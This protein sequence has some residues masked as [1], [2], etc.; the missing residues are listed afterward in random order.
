[1]TGTMICGDALAE[2]KKM[3]SGTF[4][5]IVTSPPYN[6]RRSMADDGGSEPDFRGWGPLR[7]GY[8]NYGDNLPHAEYV[9]WQNACVREMWRLL[10]PDGALFYNHKFRVG[11]RPML[12]HAGILEG[13]PVRQMVIWPRPSVNISP[14]HHYYVPNYENVYVIA[15]D[16]WR[17]GRIYGDVWHMV[18]VPG[19][20][21]PAP[22]PVALPMRCLETAPDGAPV[23]DPFMGS[24]TTAVAAE[25]MGLDWVGI[26]RSNKY[27]ELARRRVEAH[28]GQRRIDRC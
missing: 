5:C 9:A 16:E 1:M 4:G 28:A 2:M 11:R 10:R 20:D 17:V 13:V 14:G 24:G 8:E 27:C 22:F 26:E 12:D 15:R 21:H 25:R 7:D 23:L 18:Q 6:L 3:E 19:N